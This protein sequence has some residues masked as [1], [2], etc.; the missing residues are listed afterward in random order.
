M[1]PQLEKEGEDLFKKFLEWL[2]RVIAE[3]NTPQPVP[4]PTPTPVPTPVP[5]P[6]PVPTPV[7]VPEPPPPPPVPVSRCPAPFGIKLGFR[8]DARKLALGYRNIADITAIVR[9]ACAHKGDLSP[10][11]ICPADEFCGDAY[12]AA[13]GQ[14]EAFQ[15][16]PGFDHDPVERSSENPYI[17]VIA[18]NSPNDWEGGRYK[19]AGRMTIGVSYRHLNF[20]RCQDVVMTEDGRIIGGQNSAGYDLPK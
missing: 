6:A 9:G 11:A 18:T 15:T 5:T 3:A 20:W 19:A 7:P 10:D 13:L 17:L 2:R 16:G 1:S 14:P 12:N 8:Q 4:V